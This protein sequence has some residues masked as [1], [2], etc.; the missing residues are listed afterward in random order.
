MPKKISTPPPI[1]IKVTCGF[2]EGRCPYG[3][4]VYPY[5]Y[6][7][8]V[9]N[10]GAESVRLIGQH[11]VTTDSTGRTRRLEENGLENGAQP[12]IYPGRPLVYH[13]EINLLTSTGKLRGWLT[14]ITNSGEIFDA[15]FGSINLVPPP[16]QRTLH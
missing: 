3:A 12:R 7:I 14:L 5:Q 6:T 10:H 15:P 11:I 2:D 13:D 1:E 8:K 4:G 9:I 16:P